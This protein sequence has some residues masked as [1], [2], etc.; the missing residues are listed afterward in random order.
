MEQAQNHGNGCVYPLNRTPEREEQYQWV[1]PLVIGGWT[2]ISLADSL[3]ALHDLTDL[4]GLRIGAT[5]GDAIT[6]YLKEHDVAVDEISANNADQLNLKKL[7]NRRIDLWATGLVKGPYLAAKEGV[8]VRQAFL[9]K[10]SGVFMACHPAVPKV[11]IE[12]L[13]RAVRQIRNDGTADKLAKA[14]RE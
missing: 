14:Y 1:G 7:A 11:T 8:K 12:A 13:D 2:L 3:W 6:L 10:E 4:K 5:E 9:L